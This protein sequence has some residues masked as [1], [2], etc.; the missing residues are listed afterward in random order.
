MVDLLPTSHPPNHLLVSTTT[1]LG[2]FVCSRTSWDDILLSVF[3]P[4]WPPLH[5]IVAWEIRAH[6]VSIVRFFLRPNRIPLHGIYLSTFQAD[7]QCNPFRVDECWDY[8]QGFVF[9]TFK[10]FS[11]ELPG[12]DSL[13]HGVN[14]RFIL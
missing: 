9:D 13:G 11:G 6:C 7:P 5:N 8:A 4:V 14:M 3:F 10:F 1:G 2:F 12:K